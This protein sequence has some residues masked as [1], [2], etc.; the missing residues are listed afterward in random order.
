MDTQCS[1]YRR[2]NGIWLSRCLD[3]VAVSI[4]RTD[5]AA[6]FVSCCISCVYLALH[7]GRTANLGFRYRCA[8][9]DRQAFANAVRFRASD[10]YLFLPKMIAFAYQVPGMKSECAESDQIWSRI[11]RLGPSDCHIE[12][13]NAR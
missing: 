4:R 6:S 5:R 9:A 7:Y 1:I 10:L 12:E 2:V 8:I 13:W 3:A 11:R